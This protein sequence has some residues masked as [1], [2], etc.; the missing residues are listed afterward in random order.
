MTD[1]L[2][3]GIIGTGMIAGKFAA[4]I[5]TSETGRLTAVASRN[6]A[7]ADAFADEFG[8]EKRF[9]SY[10]AMLADPG[11]Q[12]VY[13]STPH[14][15]H[16]E[17]A[18]K[19]ADAGKHILCEKPITLDL[20]DAERVVEA[21]RANGVFLME[22]FMY[23]CHAQTAKLVELVRSGTIGEVRMVQA[24]FSFQTGWDPK[25]RLLDKSLGGGGILDVGCYCASMVRLVA[26]AAQGKPFA[27][28]TELKAVGR[29]GET[30]VDEWTAAVL[31][32][33]GDIVAQLSCGVQL[34]QE[35]VVRVYGSEGSILV[36]S[37]W[38]CGKDETGANLVVRKGSNTER[39]SVPESGGLYSIEADTVARTIAKGV[40][41]ADAPAMTWDD[42]LGN[43]RVLDL[44]RAEIG[45]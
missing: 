2:S 40:T 25:S 32:F 10:E 5:L 26:G 20:A 21:A 36:P 4:G 8:I 28:P 15:M 27:E 37:P 16:A 44:W 23:R 3:W 24:T 38:F 35:N 22:A 12:A 6:Q 14:P 43:M 31:K 19:A 9:A 33:P 39:I 45:G 1:K 34:N 41:Q 30:G 13:I 18:V 42:T 7:T 11:V 17:W 29:I